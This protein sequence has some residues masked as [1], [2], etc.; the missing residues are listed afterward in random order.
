MRSFITKYCSNDKNNGDH[1]MDC[2]AA[3]LQELDVLKLPPNPLDDFID[4]M[5]G[6]DKVA[7]MTGR[8]YRWVRS[9]KGVMEYVPRRRNG[10]SAD[11]INITERQEFQE[12]KK[13]VA[14]ISQVDNTREHDRARPFCT[15]LKR[16]I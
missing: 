11:S 2:R 12:G 4:R 9:R 15:G 1:E 5:S 6:P 8:R 3:L 10:A 14:I 16:R 13:L 7:E